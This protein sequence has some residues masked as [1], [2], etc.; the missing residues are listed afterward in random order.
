MR[1]VLDSIGSIY[2]LD[3]FKRFFEI[4]SGNERFCLILA[5][6]TYELADYTHNT[7]KHK[8][9][10]SHN[11]QAVKTY[12]NKSWQDIFKFNIKLAEQCL[13]SNE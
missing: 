5:A 13:I 4:E 6:V 1:T 10:L 8:H 11:Q 7:Y 3:D 2:L 12:N 9:G